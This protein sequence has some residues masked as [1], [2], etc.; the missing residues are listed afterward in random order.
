M[1]FKGAKVKEVYWTLNL[2]G[3]TW[4]L[5]AKFSHSISYTIH[6]ESALYTGDE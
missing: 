5:V 3:T 2:A 6:A 1:N 4:L